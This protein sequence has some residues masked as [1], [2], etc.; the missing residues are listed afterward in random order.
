[1][2]RL[3]HGFAG[4]H[5]LGY[6]TQRAVGTPPAVNADSLKA[7]FSPNA[8]DG[9][10]YIHSVGTTSLYRAQVRP[11]GTYWYAAANDGSRQAI[12][13]DLYSTVLSSLNGEGS[14]AI[15]DSPPHPTTGTS[16]F[17]TGTFSLGQAV[18]I[19]L[20]ATDPNGDTITFALQA[21]NLPTGWSM[22]SSGL[23][24]GSATAYGSFGFI[25]RISDSFG[26]FTDVVDTVNIGAVLPNFVGQLIA[27]ATAAVTALGLTSS[28]STFPS[29]K[30]LG[31]VLTQV[32]PPGTV[33]T[34]GLTVVFTDS[35][36]SLSVGN[37][38]VFPQ[39]IPGLTWAGTRTMI[40]RTGYQEA[41]TGKVTTLA[42]QAYPIVEWSLNYE[43]LN[44]AA[45]LDDL[46]KIEGLF[47]SLQGQSGTFLYDD[48]AFDT[49]TNG[50]FGTGNGSTKAFQL[51]GYYGNVGGPSGKEII[52]NLQN[53]AAVQIFD[54][55]VLVSPSAY[56]I[57]A[58]GIVTF[59]S[60]PLAG[61][62]LTWTGQFY[63]RCR[64]E[65][66][67]LDPSQYMINFWALQ[68]LKFRSVVL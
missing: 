10:V 53:P 7:R 52:Q 46:K 57:G 20:A 58:T 63:Y 67:D 13:A 28:A 17:N 37:P 54:N 40:L 16:F 65:V 43:L 25:T 62:A 8:A 34:S 29:A 41:I 4:R 12:Q 19:Q 64:F 56:A 66:D 33:I 45:A 47:M 14:L 42:Y 49:I 31:E 61:H 9:D 38:N 3:P 32:P 36:G 24:T 48:P 44:R 68:T 50:P 55:G 2:L 18:N 59:N 5:L 1:M 23:V 21:G 11:D 35:D 26:A 27:Q 30:P 15:N 39:N 60:A 6:Q 22:S 51:A